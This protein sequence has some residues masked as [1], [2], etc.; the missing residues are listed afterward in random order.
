M[1]TSFFRFRWPS[2]VI[3]KSSQ[4]SC[5]FSSIQ[6][7]GG[8]DPLWEA[9]K[10]SGFQNLNWPEIKA[11]NVLS[12]NRLQSD[13]YSQRKLCFLKAN[14]VRQRLYV[15]IP[16]FDLILKFKWNGTI[17][18]LA[19]TSANRHF[20]FTGSHT[21]VRNTSCSVMPRFK[22]CFIPSENMLRLTLLCD[23]K[24]RLAE[25]HSKELYTPCPS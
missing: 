22:S 13:T 21:R 19:A 11:Y 20:L 2:R 24:R 15:L 12:P 14:T 5:S 4:T 10:S 16:L 8:E 9:F 23:Q 17:G 6:S 3:P 7:W 18:P 1:E 25:R